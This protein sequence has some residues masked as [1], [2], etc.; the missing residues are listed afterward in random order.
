VNVGL[1]S[2]ADGARRAI[3]AG[4]AVTSA[5][6]HH[7][8]DPALGPVRPERDPAAR[9]QRCRGALMARSSRRD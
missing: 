7:D 5:R 9:S 4:G 3:E 1:D 2:V 6:A 8:G